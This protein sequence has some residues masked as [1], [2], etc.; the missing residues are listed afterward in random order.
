M[1]CNKRGHSTKSNKTKGHVVHVKSSKK[2]VVADVI[3]SSII[4][5]EYEGNDSSS[6]KVFYLEGM[7][8]SSATFRDA[9][10]R[11][12]VGYSAGVETTCIETNNLGQPVCI[13]LEKT[14]VIT[15]NL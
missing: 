10:I 5:N 8:D 14:V 13:K 7:H 11:D 1:Y 6:H 3:N 2:S 12:N 9:K 15:K 4:N